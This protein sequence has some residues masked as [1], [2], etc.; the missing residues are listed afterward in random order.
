MKVSIRLTLIACSLIAF[1][2]FPSDTAWTRWL[3]AEIMI[4]QWVALL[5][6]TMLYIIGTVFALKEAGII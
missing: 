6:G 1:F 4:L 3:P 5:L 2:Y